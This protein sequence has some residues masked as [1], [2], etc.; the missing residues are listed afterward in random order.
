MGGVNSRLR[1]ELS[2]KVM[3]KPDVSYLKSSE[4]TGLLVQYH[5]MLVINITGYSEALGNDDHPL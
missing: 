1:R 3:M 2:S 4:G 5:R